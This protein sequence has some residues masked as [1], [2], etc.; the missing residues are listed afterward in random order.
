MAQL[1]RLPQVMDRVG[2]RPTRIYDLMGDGSFPKPIRLGERAV[3]WLESE[4]DF[5]FWLRHRSLEL[6]SELLLPEGRGPKPRD[7]SALPKR[8]KAASASLLAARSISTQQ[9][10]STACEM[11][12]PRPV[13][14]SRYA[15]LPGAGRH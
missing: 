13:V 8:R 2:L 3:A 12:A 1:L 11:Y 15:R 9:Q 4:V 10:D 14:G 7:F 6:K 5:G